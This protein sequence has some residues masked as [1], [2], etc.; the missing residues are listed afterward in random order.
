MSNEIGLLTK[1][2]GMDEATVTEKLKTPEGVK[3]IEDTIAGMKIFKTNAEYTSSMNN[4]KDMLK[5]QLYNDHKAS[6]LEMSEKKILEKNGLSWKR[7]TDFNSLDELVD[8]IADE[9][10]KAAKAGSSGDNK[11]LEKAQAK[12][13][14]LTNQMNEE[15]TKLQNEF[16]SKL[17]S[18]EID[19]TLSGIKPLL[20][21]ESDKVNTTA[22][23]I[24][25][26]FNQEYNLREKDGK[27]IV[28][29]GDEIHRDANYKEVPLEV[30]MMEVA[31]KVAKIKS[32]PAAGRG[33]DTNT[34]NNPDSFDFSS[35]AT[36]D[37]FLET[38]TELRKLTNGHPTLLKYYEAFKKSKG[39]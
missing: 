29:K 1:V 19:A 30:V 16:G 14:E 17:I 25:Y 31:S 35:F 9:K 13:A 3:E 38:Q 22:D 10:V 24:K 28:F 6:V 5:D 26:S 36:W 32:S 4:Y 33:V 12:I 37:A 20:D 39:Q 34:A 2:V 18:K 11:E 15:K 23:F 7:G 8:K 21:I 27:Y